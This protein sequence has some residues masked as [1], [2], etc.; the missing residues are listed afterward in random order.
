MK[1]I[2]KLT[3]LFNNV[4]HSSVTDNE[5]IIRIGEKNTR[6]DYQLRKTANKQAT[7]EREREEDRTVKACSKH[8]IHMHTHAEN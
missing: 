8:D 5:M 2:I 1:S 3:Y 6:R 7:R 4:D